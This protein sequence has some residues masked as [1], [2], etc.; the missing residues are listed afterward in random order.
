M[1]STYGGG[2]D[3]IAVLKLIWLAIRKLPVAERRKAIH[4]IS[5]D[6][7][8]EQPLVARWVDTSLDRMRT[9]AREQELPVQPHKLTP[10]VANSFWVNLIGRGYP[11]PSQKFRWCTERL[12]I[13]PSNAFIRGTIK[14]DERSKG[15][16]RI[17]ATFPAVAS[18]DPP[19]GPRQPA[20]GPASPRPGRAGPSVIRRPAG[21]GPRAPRSAPPGPPR[22]GRAVA[23]APRR[24]GRS[25][26]RVG[27]RPRTAVMGRSPWACVPAPR[28]LS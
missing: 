16:E 18:P 6:T 12:K 10:E 5:T 8:V 22:P 28:M 2:K 23:S 20:D 13:K 17:S 27:N 21:S 19:P 25:G 1:E 14:G 9:A 15:T 26:R 3:S 4:V 24:P 11:A 7:L